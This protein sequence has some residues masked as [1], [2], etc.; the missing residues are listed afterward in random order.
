MNKEQGN[1]IKK[2]EQIETS[3]SREALIESA[4]KMREQMIV[5]AEKEVADIE[6]T[7][8]GVLAEDEA[9]AAREGLEIDAEDRQELQDL[10]GEARMV[11]QDLEEKFGEFVANHRK[12]YGENMMNTLE[13]A[14]RGK[15][16]AAADL[17]SIDNNLEKYKTRVEA[18]R[19]EIDEK[20]SNIINR[21]IEFKK[22]RELE[23]NLAIEKRILEDYE[24]RSS[25]KK[26]LIKAYDYLIDEETKLA[27][28]IE[29]AHK[30]NA[31]WDENKRQEMIREEERRDVAKLA[32]EHGVFFVSSI[33]DNEEKPSQNNRAI[34]TKKLNFNDQLDILHGLDPTIAA[35]TLHMGT[36]QKT[37]GDGSWGVF[38][39]GGRVLGGE[40]SDAGS[41]VYGLRDRRI[42]K[43]S[44][45]TKA[46]ENAILRKLWSEDSSRYEDSTSYNELVVENPEIAGV[47]VTWDNSFP[48]LNQETIKLENV[49]GGVRYDRWWKNL[50]DVM[51]RGLP[52]F[53]LNREN[54][55]V[56][57]MYD[58]DVENKSFKV[59]PEYDPE[60][61]ANMPGTY[62]QH[63]GK[64][65]K[66]KA[67]M[68]VF[69]KVTG[70][71]S[72][73]ER[74]LYAPDGTENDGRGLY[75]VH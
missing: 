3:Q 37:F 9:R 72:E 25:E 62:Q 14:Q 31:Q 48:N 5:D 73:E 61:I 52:L 46:I 49:K 27:A 63:L 70:L 42:S 41:E 64:E 54:N 6:K 4:E 29:E 59:T 65:E 35:S 11:A 34:N 19:N 57:M 67:V 66:R 43:N 50:Q 28:L 16:F 75:N 38:I 68:R 20:K 58:I 2:A 18:L 13:E 44:R 32:K 69:D 10:N 71:I 24:K 21:I 1:R 55:T 56:R 45:T 8:A 7:S 22:I 60:N 23:K 47:Y 30:E 15:K 53:V 39:S 40:R 33:V 26:E 74:N 51:K 36:K 12:F 17:E